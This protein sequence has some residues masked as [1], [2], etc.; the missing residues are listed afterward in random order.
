MF[1]PM[2][3]NLIDR[4]QALA[5][6]LLVG[7][8][9]LGWPAFAQDNLLRNGSFEGMPAQGRGPQDW[10]DCNISTES[11]VDVHSADTEYFEVREQPTHGATFLGMV[12]RDNGTIEGVSQ[13]LSSPL[14]IGKRYSFFVDLKKTLS[15][16]SASRRTH[17]NINYQTPV[18][19]AI[20]FSTDFCSANAHHMM[21][22]PFL[23]D[24]SEWQDVT[25]QFTATINA[26][27]IYIFAEHCGDGEYY[28]GNVLLDFAQLVEVATTPKAEH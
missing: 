4:H 5:A 6:V 12:A 26:H 17:E 25:F 13:R 23:V 24:Y 14:Q 28:S 11:P 8:L 27:Y 19:L 9:G 21:N 22:E 1:K 18:C 20:Y 16:I 15:Y 2:I 7:S 3:Y 10:Y